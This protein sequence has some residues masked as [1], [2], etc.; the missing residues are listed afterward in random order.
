[1][2][3]RAS[4]GFGALLGAWLAA[5]GA[6]AHETP[7]PR[8]IVLEALTE[9]QALAF[10][11][12]DFE[13][14]DFTVERISGAPS[15][16]ARILPGSLRWVRTARWVVVP[17]AV[18]E[19]EARGASSGLVRYAGFSQPLERTPAGARAEVPVVLLSAPGYPV[20]ARVVQD[21]VV[22]EARFVIRFAPRAHQRGQVLF[23]SAC[24]PLGLRVA[25]GSIPADSFLFVG[26][27]TIRTARED[28]T[29][30]TVELHLLFDHPR[31]RLLLEG[32]ALEPSVDSLYT[33]RTSARPSELRLGFLDPPRP[34][35]EIVLAHGVPE[36]LPSG[37]LGLGVGPYRYEY[38]EG[39]TSVDAQVPLITLYAGYSFSPTARL[40]YFNA[41]APHRKGSS[42]QGFYLWF[43]QGRYVDERLSVNLLLGAN[44]LVYVHRSE[45]VARIS[46]PQGFELIVRDLFGQNRNLTLG[47]FLYPRILGR[48]YYNLWLRW[49]PPQVFGELNYIEWE[50]PHGRA[51]PTRT[52]TFGVSFG[53]P[54]LR[55]L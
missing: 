38:S 27:R 24:S 26:C 12:A 36:T 55:F 17:R 22:Q 41:T 43:E 11:P 29:A 48:S 30:A 28:D 10:A 52:R 51:P 21:G 7:W 42:D 31:A 19:V 20:Q 13:A 15:I 32:V 50:E 16:R 8:S 18:L 23:D 53:G 45:A 39:A 9:P 3:Q 47:A 33:V 2:A 54:L 6:L 25:R 1:L 34:D 4:W 37:F 40:V 44:V 14:R 5:G 35:H 49:G 46:V